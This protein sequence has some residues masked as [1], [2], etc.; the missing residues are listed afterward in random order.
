MDRHAGPMPIGIVRWPCDVEFLDKPAE[1]YENRAIAP[2]L[3][4]AGYAGQY[5]Q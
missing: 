5:N 2:S 1:S 3:A 4:G